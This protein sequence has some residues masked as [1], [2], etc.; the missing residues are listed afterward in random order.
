MWILLITD[1]GVAALDKK[2]EREDQKEIA[3]P[4]PVYDRHNPRVTCHSFRILLDI[5]CIHPYIVQ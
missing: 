2:K 1:H 5:M 4:E 3:N